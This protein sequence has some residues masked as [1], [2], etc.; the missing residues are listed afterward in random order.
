ML[1][2]PHTPPHPLLP[3]VLPAHLGMHEHL[4][5]VFKHVE[6]LGQLPH[7]P[8]HPSSPHDLPT[9]LRR[10]SHWLLNGEQPSF[11]VV[12]HSPQKLPH[13]SGPHVPGTHDGAQLHLKFGEQTRPSAP[14]I[15]LVKQLPH[16]PLHPS[17]PHSLPV[18]SGTQTQLLFEAHAR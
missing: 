18:Q 17:L 2:K 11:A 4:L 16:D 6:P 15:E 8:P 12:L 1:H 14:P 13:P 9:Q 10:H 3:H 7:V 5:V